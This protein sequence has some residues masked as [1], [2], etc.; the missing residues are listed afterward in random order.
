MEDCCPLQCGE[1]ARSSVVG[2]LSHSASMKWRSLEESTPGIDTR[3]L[4]EQLAERKDLIAKYVQ[5]DTTEVHAFA[6]V[7][8]LRPRFLDRIL[9]NSAESSPT[10][11]CVYCI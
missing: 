11:I 1:S 6:I 9:P 7:D 8:E 4:R 5:T 3:T 2:S 10:T